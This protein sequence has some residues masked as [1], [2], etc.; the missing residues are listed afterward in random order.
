MASTA[1]TPALVDP[2]L[3]AVMF[4]VLALFAFF[5]IALPDN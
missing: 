5:S 2:L 3:E 4:L 1:R